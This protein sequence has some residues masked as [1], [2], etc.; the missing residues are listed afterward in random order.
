MA[1]VALVA[2]GLRKRMLDSSQAALSASGIEG[3]LRCSEEL[4]SGI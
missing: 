3:W 2:S 4:A 1:A